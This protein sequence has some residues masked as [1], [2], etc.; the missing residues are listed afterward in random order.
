MSSAPPGGQHR[1]THTHTTHEVG[2]D[3]ELQAELRDVLDANRYLV[4]GT[5]G[6]DG[7]PRVSPVYFTHHGYRALYWVSSP[8]AQH[9]HNVHHHP[10]IE[11]VVFDSTRAPGTTQAAYLRGTAVEVAEQELVEEC[12]RA[13]AGVGK[14][15][16]PFAPEEL[17]GDADLRLFRLDVREY[18][19]HVRG[20]SERGLGIDTRFGITMPDP[21]AG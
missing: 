3:P 9:T 6:P 21:E 1:M 16:R 10:D 17:S 19:V 15:A 7:H 14:G 5:V 11:V 2:A 4:L 8:D 20:G 12:R 18:A 13:F